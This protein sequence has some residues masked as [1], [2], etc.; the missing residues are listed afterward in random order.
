LPV[1]PPLLLL[2]VLELMLVVVKLLVVERGCY[3][4][5]ASRRRRVR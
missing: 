1:S 2:L 5:T 3:V 4:G